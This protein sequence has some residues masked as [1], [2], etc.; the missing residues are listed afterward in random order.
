VHDLSS[1]ENTIQRD[2]HESDELLGKEC[3]SCLRALTYNHFRR[4]TSHKDGRAFQCVSC[5]RSPRLST[6]E[7]V[8]RLRE[9]NNNS[10]AVRAQRWED[11]DEYKK[12]AARVGKSM[13]HVEFFETLKQITG[14]KIYFEQGAFE[15][16]LAIY[17]M[18]G[19]PQPHLEGMQF[20]YLFYCPKG[21]M[22]EYSLHE[23]DAQRDVPKKEILRGWRQVL[24]N[25]IRRA[26]ITEDEAHRVFG[27]PTGE[28]GFTY[29]RDLYRWR[30]RKTSTTAEKARK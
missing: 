3:V 16:D 21:T 23:F 12:Y 6:R 2:L 28:G 5:E 14:D 8:D 17:R 1:V 10:E 18:Y 13:H 11:Q 27:P 15:S 29:R 19:V 22:P 24:L 20:E 25:L 9:M 7:H 26:I 4:D 30:N